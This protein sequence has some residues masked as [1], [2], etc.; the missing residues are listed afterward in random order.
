V[1][2]RLFAPLLISTLGAFY[3]ASGGCS[4]SSST[5]GGGGCES[6]CTKWVGARCRNGPTKEKC[7]TE[8]AERES[9]CQLENDAFLKCAT[10]EA[11]IAC[12]TGSGQP[13]VVGCAP[14]ESALSSCIAC[15][16]FCEGWAKIGCPLSPG[17]EEC[18]TVCMDRRCAQ[19]HRA[20]ADCMFVGSGTCGADGRPIPNSCFT[21]YNSAAGC[22]EPLGQPQPFRYI[23]I[24]LVDDAGRD[25]ANDSEV[26]DGG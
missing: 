12:E 22:T 26:G 17:R 7:L 23:P 24:V 4:S 11:T 20:V 13:R 21:E 25:A 15:D 8:C 5:I 19:R 10:I 2:R 9:R 6:F 3:A 14:R 16:R 1:V 18:L